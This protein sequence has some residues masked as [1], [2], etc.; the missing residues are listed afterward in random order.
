MFFVTGIK[1]ENYVQVSKMYAR[2]DLGISDFHESLPVDID[3]LHHLRFV[4]FHAF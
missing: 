2:A 1:M 3:H 4:H